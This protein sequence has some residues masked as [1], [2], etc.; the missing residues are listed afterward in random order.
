M[1]NH[2]R[3]PDEEIVDLTK[4]KTKTKEFWH[5]LKSKKSSTKDNNSSQAMHT[6]HRHTERKEQHNQEKSTFHEFKEYTTHNARWIIPVFLILIAVIFS[7]YLRTMPLRMPIADDWAQ[8]TVY[9]YY[10]NQ[11]TNQINEQYPNLPEQNKGALVQREWQT[12]YVQNQQLIDSQITQLAEEYRNKFRDDSGTLYILGIDPYHY[13]RL[14]S[15][16]LTYGHPGTTIK[17]G[18]PWDEYF[19][20][21]EGRSAGKDFHAYF[22]ALLHKVMNIG[23]SVPLMTSFFY[24]GVI[25]SALATIPAFFIG[26][27]V[28]GNNV[29]G[30]FA[31]L[32][33]A[34]SAFFVSR[35]TG[36]SSD[37]DVYT[38]F[39][40]L[41][42]LWL[43]IEAYEARTLKRGIILSLAAGLATGFFSAAWIGGWWYIFLF[44][45]AAAGL[46][47]IIHALIHYKELKTYIRST[48][49]TNPLVLLGTYIVSSA[50]F[51]SI[52]SSFSDFVNG[53][54]GPLGFLRIKAVGVTSLWPNIRTTVAELNVPPFSAVVDQLGGAI[55]LIIAVIGIVLALRRR[56]DGERDYKVALLLAMWLVAS[57]FATTKGVRFILQVIPVLALAVGIGLGILW[58]V[59]SEWLTRTLHVNRK[60]AMVLVFL[61]FSLLFIKPVQ[62][63]YQSAYNSVPSVNDDWY[64]TLTKINTQGDKNAVINSWW[65]FGHWF[66]AI[67]NRPVTFDGAAQTGHGAYW[68]GKAL[69]TN[70]E[71]NTIGILRMLNCGQNKA[72]ETL[73][74]VWN[75]TPRSID[76]LNYI[77]TLSDN[78]AR[79]TLRSQ[80]LTSEQVD[81]V[82]RFTHCNAPT[83]YFI[84]SEDMI[85]KAGVW[86]HFG[87]WDFNRAVM[88]Q[89][90]KTMNHD[91]AITFLTTRFNLSTGD[92]EQY[93]SEIQTTPA[94][95]WISPWPS[96]VSGMSECQTRGKLAQCNV[97]TQQGTVPVSIDLENGTAMIPGPQNQILYPVSLVYATKEGIVEKRFNGTTIGFSVILVPSG[98]TYTALFADSRHAASTFTKLFFFEGH[99][100][101]CFSNFDR[102]RSFTGGK[103]TTWTVDYDCNQQN[104]VFFLP[105]EKVM[106]AHILVGMDKRSEEEARALIEAIASNITTKNFASYA[107]KYSDD[108][109]SRMRGG[110]L[111]EFGKGV[112]VKEFEE[113]AFSLEKGG[114]SK[115]FRTP[116]GYHIIYVKERTED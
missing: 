21:P 40:P 97:G 49:V 27:K 9:N 98:E 12:Y 78:G 50:I 106:A 35:T 54:L 18:E 14:V 57:L 1:D 17:N 87:S 95:N 74:T 13:Y 69:I 82:L 8:N 6:E 2:S 34:T 107:E 11:L 39:F 22:G 29:G 72:F 92:A 59:I 7:V 111:G 53:F 66:K 75:D 36:E 16:V 64:N 77:V 80:G 5:S 44:A 67:A 79:E 65:D 3:K 52:F 101:K 15:N 42:V 63:G 103:I 37:T 28:S 109:G 110:D 93:V 10:Q 48:A 86:G 85:G 23:S 19:V 105:V 58:S 32:I 33:V 88:Y 51:V 91:E 25:F 43:F 96:Y 99:G 26:R 81:E 62:A 60:I 73:E 24:I 38:V 89:T 4:I 55:L 30:F 114:I 90:T 47:L 20:Y 31:A 84:T 71:K 83:D 68:I 100:M 46:T 102:V 94:D 112:M 56:V 113:V 115:P 116:F 45:L 104:K 76:T 61:L 108:P 70:D 41:L